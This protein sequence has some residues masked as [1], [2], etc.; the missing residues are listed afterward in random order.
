MRYTSGGRQEPSKQPPKSL[1][2]IGAG[3]EYGAQAGPSAESSSLPMSWSV[4]NRR[5]QESP[6]SIVFRGTAKPRCR[7]RFFPRMGAAHRFAG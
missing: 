2:K 1:E 4:E 7:P 5:T 6:R 3:A